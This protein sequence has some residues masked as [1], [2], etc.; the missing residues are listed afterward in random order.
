[1]RNIFILAPLSL[2]AS[3][4][5]LATPV[6]A[7]S[8]SRDAGQLRSEITQLD[9]QVQKQNGSSRKGTAGLARQVDQLQNLYRSYSRNG[10]TRPE[11]RTL[12][13]RIE[14]VRSQVHAAGRHDNGA[15]RD[16]RGTATRSSRGGNHRR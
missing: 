3:A 9:R 1:M 10:F 16:D 4:L 15:G 8:V 11:I 2:A 6:S 5:L 7:A 13:A 14:S 12:T